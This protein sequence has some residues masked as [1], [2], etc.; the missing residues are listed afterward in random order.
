MGQGVPPWRAV[1][2]FAL[3][4]AFFCYGFVHRVAP[5]VMVELVSVGEEL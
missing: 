2:A 4:A 5:S 1:A 3:A